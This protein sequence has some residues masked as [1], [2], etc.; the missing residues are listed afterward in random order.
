MLFD[1]QTVLGGGI[2]ITSKLNPAANGAYTVFKLGFELAS[3]DTPFYY[4]AE[5]TRAAGA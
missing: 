3:R 2:N 5:G 4:I 1:N